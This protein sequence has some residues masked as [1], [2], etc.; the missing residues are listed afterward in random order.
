MSFQLLDERTV[1]NFIKT[2]P[3]V[4]EIIN[5]D[6]G[7]IQTKELGTGNMNFIY[8]IE[9]ELNG[10]KKGIIIKQVITLFT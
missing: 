7:T 3:Q 4:A 8:L 2:V 9:Q 10:K 6:E 1:V 5:T